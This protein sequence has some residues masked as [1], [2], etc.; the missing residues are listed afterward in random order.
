MI[1]KTTNTNVKKEEDKKTDRRSIGL[2][3][4]FQEETHVRFVHHVI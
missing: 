2:T 4:P 3:K 1:R